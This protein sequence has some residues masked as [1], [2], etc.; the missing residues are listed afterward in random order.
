MIIQEYLIEELST[1]TKSAE[2]LAQYLQIVNEALSSDRRRYRKDDSRYVYYEQHHILPKSLYPYYA[3]DRANLVLLTAEEHFECHKL[4]VEIFPTPEMRLAY[5][6]MSNFHNISKEEYDILRQEVSAAMSVKLAGKQKTDEHKL[7]ISE[8]RLGLSY[9]PL[10]SAHKQK[11]SKALQGTCPSELNRAICSERCKKR[12]GS[13]NT[14]SRRVKCT[15]DGLVFD[16]V[17]ECERY[18][19]VLHLYRYCATGKIYSKLNK[20]FEYIKD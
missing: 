12:T 7:H 5:G 17:G 9:G 16:T 8:G 19:N 15:E 13:K 14:Q 4:L 11:I 3:K 1:S 20:H 6:F 10:S 18:Y 2:C